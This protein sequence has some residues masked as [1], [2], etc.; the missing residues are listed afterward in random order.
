MQIGPRYKK[1]RY[2]GVPVFRKT[3]TQKYA[4]RAQRKQKSTKRRSQKSEY[5][6][7]MLEKQKARY[8][9]GVS[10]GQ[11]SKYVK[12]ALQ[13]TGD[14]SKNLLHILEG[15]LDNVVVRAGFAPTRSAS[16]QMV[17]HG[18]IMVNGKKVTIPSYEV[19]TGDVITIRQGSQG[20]ALFAKLNEELKNA[21]A[22][23]WLAVD[24]DKKEIKVAGIPDADTNDLLFD[25]R[26]VLE[27]YTR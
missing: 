10:S 7:Q 6:R 9:Y 13:T 2:L 26:S 24:P 20:K 15:R 27:F 19:S 3:Q 21:K 16:R 22:P 17:S 1:A 23:A 5:G 14:N 8:S 25:V 11:F 12:L 18:H 4:M